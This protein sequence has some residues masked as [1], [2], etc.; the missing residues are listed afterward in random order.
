MIDAATV[1]TVGRERQLRGGDF[2][3]SSVRVWPAADR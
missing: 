1:S 2:V 3:T